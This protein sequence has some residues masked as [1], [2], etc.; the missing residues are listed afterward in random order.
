MSVSLENYQQIYQQAYK[1]Y[2]QA[3]YE[4]AASLVDQVLDIV[5]DDSNIHL[6]RGHVYFVLQQYEVA[7]VEYETVLKLSDDQEIIN[8]AHNGLEN[9]PF[10]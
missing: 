10:S 6:L 2:V 1:A 4:E 5:P 8:L 9:V 7:K 3:N